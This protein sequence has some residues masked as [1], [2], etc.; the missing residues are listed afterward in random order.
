MNVLRVLLT[1]AARLW[2]RPQHHPRSGRWPAVRRAWLAKHPRCAVCGGKRKCEAHHVLPHQIAPE[3]ELSKRNLITL[4]R[5]ATN[6]H[7]LFGHLGDF[8]AYNPAVRLDAKLWRAKIR[9]RRFTKP[10]RKR[11]CPQ[12][13]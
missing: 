9:L 6:C 11:K 7:L 12:G 4:C 1:L 13:K 3:L 10:K 2:R 5:G 8:A